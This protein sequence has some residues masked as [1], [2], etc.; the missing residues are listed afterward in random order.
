MAVQDPK[1]G[2]SRTPYKMVVMI[3]LWV[4]DFDEH[5]DLVITAKRIVSNEVANLIHEADFTIK[6]GTAGFSTYIKAIEFVSNH[7]LN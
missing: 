7:E 6:E 5:E 2:N 3:D 1:S 4:D